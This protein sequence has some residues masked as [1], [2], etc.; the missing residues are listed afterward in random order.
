MK[1]NLQ[2]KRVM[3]FIDETDKHGSKNLS[4]AIVEKAKQLGC[5]GATVLRGILGFGAHKRVHSASIVDLSINLPEI[6]V[7]MDAAE[8]IDLLLPELD[9]MVK[10]GLVVVDDVE[11]FKYSV[12]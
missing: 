1:T 7:I 5:G 12:Y 9:N 8:V 10:E 4:T 6:I 3:I 11:G 2:L